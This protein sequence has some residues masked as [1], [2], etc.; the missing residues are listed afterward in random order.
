MVRR[1]SKK[2]SKKLNLDIDITSLMD[3]IT[4]LAVFLLKNFDA[5]GIELSIPKDITV[6]DSQSS[7]TPRK[8]V[9]IHMNKELKLWVDDAYVADLSIKGRPNFDRDGRRIIP[10][11]NELVQKKESLSVLQKSAKGVSEFSGI[12]NLMMDKSLPYEYIRRIM[13]TSTEAGFKEFKF[14][15]IS[16]E[17]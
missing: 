1:V 15:V 9:K 6:P 13:Y 7:T 4:I 14:I 11:Y 10:L 16:K 2:R 12:I 3:I 5:A 8:A 17:G